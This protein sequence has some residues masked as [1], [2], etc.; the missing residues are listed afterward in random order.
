ML[1]Q[2]ISVVTSRRPSM[3]AGKHCSLRRTFPKLGITLASHNLSRD[4]K[5]KPNMLWN[6]LGFA[7]WAADAQ[8]SIG[9]A[10]IKLEAY[11]EAEQCLLQALKLAPGYAFAYSNLGLLREKQR[12]LDA[13]ETAFK[14]AIELQ[15]DLV[16]PY[17]NLCC[18]LNARKAH[19]AAERI[20]RDVIA[21]DARS[22][23]A[24][25]SLGG[26]LF[27]LKRFDAAEEACLK[28]I[29]LDPQFPDAWS[30]LGGVLLELR[31]YEAA[32]EAC[33]RAISLNPKLADAWSNLGGVLLAMKHHDAA[34]EAC[35]KATNL[36]P[37]LANAWYN[38][39]VTL[40]ITKQ[41]KRAIE[42]YLRSLD[43]NPDGD[44]LLGRIIH[45]RLMLSDWTLF[46]SDLDQT[47][48]AIHCERKVADPY[49]VLGLTTD[50][51]LQQKAAQIYAQDKHP[52]N[53]TLPEIHQ[54]AKHDKIRIGYFS[55]DFRDHPV[56]LLTAELF[57][58]HDRSQFEVMALSFGPDTEDGTRKRLI[59][60]F[61]KFLDVRNQSAQEIATL[62]RNLE[63][64]IAVD[65]GG[66][67]HDCRTEIFAMRAAPV[68]VNYL[69]YS[70]TMGA[71]F[72]DYLIADSTILPEE[73]KQF[74]TEKVAYLPCFF[75]SDT[76]R[77][78]S[79]RTFSREELGLPATGFVFCCFNNNYKITPYTF[80]TW[81]RILKRVD[82]SVLWLSSMN[83][84]AASNLKKEAEKR[85]VNA[86][87]I[88]FAQRVPLQED[89]LARLP[90]ADLFLDTLPYNAH[91]TSSDAL[92]AGLP[93]L[94]C[95]G[96]AFAGRVAASLLNS[97]H[98][99]ELITS[100]MEEYEASAVELANN[101]TKL[102]A[103]RK[104]LARNRVT[105][106]LFDIQSYTR[107]IEAAYTAMYERGQAGLP[108]DHI[109]TI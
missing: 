72:M 50:P 86:E 25:S 44:Y 89:H 60:A 43:L 56:S 90:L 105:T 73:S 87:R 95:L 66:Y 19:D 99:P 27:S 24:W 71:E 76:H 91:T 14:K 70:G 64:D 68:Q 30:T 38:W 52:I 51:S 41:Y 102:A 17:L 8:N 96:Q 40:S 74:Y 54:Y 7:H 80:D 42:C 58:K 109:F 29:S 12:R 81:M 35:L 9:L 4:H 10:F 62:A 15:P 49:I 33:R 21:L 45:S 82:G 103:I 22:P 3:H 100:T 107:H 11:S 32:A 6:R 104:K 83:E 16:P 77:P 47:L 39:G 1:T 28:A 85:G 88:I 53:R 108:P 79:N 55:A 61:D 34:E 67:T 93:V 101:P 13:A 65:L 59:G 92:W 106:P 48:H 36:D 20:C 23:H 37:K 2:P 46:E 26:T 97:I 5:K 78:I 63:L 94:T 98:L 69:G 57:E 18:V 31:R 84:T 75:P